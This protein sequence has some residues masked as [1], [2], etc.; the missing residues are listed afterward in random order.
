MLIDDTRPMRRA[1]NLARRQKSRKSWVKRNKKFKFDK[2][3]K[4]KSATS[5]AAT[6]LN[7]NTPFAFSSNK[8]RANKKKRIKNR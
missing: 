5:S 4:I 3:E 7:F 8:I 2:I 1:I 6:K